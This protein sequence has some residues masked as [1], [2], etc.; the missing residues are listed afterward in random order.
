MKAKPPL[1]RRKFA[2]DWDEIQYL[3]QKLLY[4]L[5]EREDAAKAARFA[6][7]L[8][9]LLSIV[10]P[11]HDA[12]LSQECWSLI[13]ETRSDIPKAIEYRESEIRL[14]R[15]LH[16]LCR[17]PTNDSFALQGRGFGDLSDRL[18]LLAT[19]YHAS[20]NCDRAIGLLRESKRLCEE[21][22][23]EFDGDGL[24]DEYLT[25]KRSPP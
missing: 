16:D 10:D 15:Q 11:A 12:I 5:Y 25:E 22:G 6:E 3:Y 23:I 13:Y 20:G 1:Q 7:R 17:E 4:W 14:M 2:S 21:Q 24:L 8:A 9:R 18:D 19:L